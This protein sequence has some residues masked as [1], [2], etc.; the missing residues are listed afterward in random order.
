MALL[1]LSAAAIAPAALA[2]TDFTMDWTNGNIAATFNSGDDAK[3]QM[4]ASGNTFGHFYA[5]DTGTSGYPGYGV[6]DSSADMDSHITAGGGSLEFQYI[7]TDSFALI[8][9]GDPTQVGQISNSFVSSSGTGTLDFSAGSNSHYL[10]SYTY[11]VND[12]QTFQATG[13]SFVI[14]HSLT[15][16]LP[17]NFGAVQVLSTGSGGSASVSHTY[18]MSGYTG[19]SFSFGAGAGVWGT[20]ISATGSGIATV[21]GYGTDNLV[22]DSYGQASHWSMPNGGSYFSQ[23]TYDSGLT[24][25]DYGFSGN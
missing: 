5:V 11:G 15:S 24:V 13:A 16:S 2:A 9:Y 21:T 23:W 7:R 4:W 1:L 19:D 6:D 14:A 22:D 18:D 12:Q 3:A 17:A 10:Q 20:S 25:T 8:Q